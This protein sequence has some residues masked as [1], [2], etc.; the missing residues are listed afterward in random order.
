MINNHK[1]T[2]QFNMFFVDN[3]LFVTKTIDI[4]N[5]YPISMWLLDLFMIQKTEKEKKLWEKYINNNNFYK[6]GYEQIT[7]SSWILNN[8]YCKYIKNNYPNSFIHIKNVLQKFIKH[9]IWSLSLNYRLEIMFD[10]F[11]DI[12]MYS[13]ASYF[14]ASKI[15]TNMALNTVKCAPLQIGRYIFIMF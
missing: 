8:S 4:H 14:I 7:I 2:Q 11:N 13:L 15:S 9:G 5:K 12:T 6:Y 3:S 1:L 10:S